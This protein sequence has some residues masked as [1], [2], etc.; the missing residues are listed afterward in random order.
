MSELP[1]ELKGQGLMLTCRVGERVMIGDEIEV[2]VR[3]MSEGQVKISFIAPPEVRVDRY[4]VWKRRM[5]E[6]LGQRQ[7]R[8][9]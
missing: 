6:R 2:V 5:L 1:S 8:G 4:E 7:R 3:S 9:R